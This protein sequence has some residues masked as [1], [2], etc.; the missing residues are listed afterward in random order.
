MENDADLIRL[1]RLD[2]YLRGQLDEA[3]RLLLEE[4]LRQN[5]DLRLELQA[6][7][8]SQDAI[9]S[10]PIRQRI[11]RIHLEHKQ[12]AEDTKVRQLLAR[13]AFSFGWGRVAAAML[14]LGLFSYS[15]YFLL[16]YRSA[17]LYED[18]FISYRLPI[19]RSAEESTSVPDSLYL[20]QEYRQ[21][22]AHVQGLASPGAKAYFLAGIS[23]MQLKNFDEAVMYFNKL[24][25]QNNQSE[26]PLFRDETDYYQALALLRTG[27]IEQA[28]SLFEQI[29]QQPDHLFH[30]NVSRSELWKL[31][32]LKWKN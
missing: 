4:E 26:E 11:R 29:R 28:R 7:R 19:A 9:R 22:L 31:T 27:N 14:L 8:L 2:H 10:Y 30:D 6:M 24:R 16:S 15:A 23:S 20:R 1:E 21:L 13:P 3:D 5:E 25:E 18:N 17:D 32:L 12:Q